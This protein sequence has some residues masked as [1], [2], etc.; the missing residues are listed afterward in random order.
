MRPL[1]ANSHAKQLADSCADKRV[2]SQTYQEVGSCDDM[3]EGGYIDAITSGPG[4]DDNDDDNG[5]DQN[6]RSDDDAHH[7]D[8][9]PNGRPTRQV[10]FPDALPD[11]DGRHD[12]P[13]QQA[14]GAKN[15]IPPDAPHRTLNPTPVIGSSKHARKRAARQAT[16]NDLDS[17]ATDGL[18]QLRRQILARNVVA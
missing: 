6:E 12:S 3:L 5:A 13:P 2:E 4:Q 15:G 1:L 14:A 9:P 11:D 8:G 18:N 17:P 10:R 16:E 7:P